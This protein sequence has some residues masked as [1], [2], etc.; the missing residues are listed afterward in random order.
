MKTESAIHQHA[1]TQPQAEAAMSVAALVM[2]IELQ[3]ALV[4]ASAAAVKSRREDL[5]EWAELDSARNE[6]AENTKE[7]RNEIAKLAK[8]YREA[9]AR[10]EEGRALTEARERLALFKGKLNATVME[11]R[12]VLMPF[13][14]GE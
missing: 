14:E 1:I 3:T 10:T 13:A 9:I 6:F 8:A 4:K 12:Q 5:S 7:T 2:R 11:R